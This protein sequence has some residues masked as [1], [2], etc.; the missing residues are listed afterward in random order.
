MP[1]LPEVETV[2]RDLERVLLNLL[3]TKVDVL[4]T[5]T[6][7]P[8]TAAELTKKLHNQSITKITR[9]GK[10][11]IFS[12]HKGESVLLVHLKMTGQMIWQDKETSFAGGHSFKT[13]TTAL[14]NKHTRLVIAFKG[15]AQLFFNDLRL[16][17]YWKF[18][19]PVELEKIKSAYGI[20]PLTENFTWPNFKKALSGRKTNIK[21]LLLNQTIISGLGNIYV[22]EAL[23]RAKILPSRRVNTLSEVELKKLWQAC[24]EVIKLGV[25]H[26]GTTF[27]HFVDGHG[28]KGGFLK[29]LEVYGKK[30]QPCS[31]CGTPI[32]KV[33]LAGRGTHFCSKCQV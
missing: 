10:L 1:E 3:I 11:L 20:E 18:A 32:K 13:P 9:I 12:L 33:S 30:G 8:L 21:A 31:R 28:K 24:H 22:D 2:R 29:F 16:F 6:I 26:R 19:E 17:G 7:Q 25:K 5:K 15:G 14:P 23:W 27:N 4:H